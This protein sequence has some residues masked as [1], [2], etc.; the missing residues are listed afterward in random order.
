MKFFQRG[1]GVDR[2]ARLS[3]ID[4]QLKER[5]SPPRSL[6]VRELLGSALRDIEKLW[7]NMTAQEKRSLLM[8]LECQIVLDTNA[9]NGRLITSIGETEVYF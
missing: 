2:E 8:V 1:R 6:D 4:A 5:E 7:G 9:G 3:V